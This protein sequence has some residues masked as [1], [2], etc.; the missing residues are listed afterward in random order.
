LKDEEPADN[1]LTSIELVL[2]NHN[3]LV[4]MSR[5]PGENE[6]TTIA[7]RTLGQVVHTIHHG[8]REERPLYSLLTSIE[9]VL[10][11]HNHLV[12]M[13]R[14]P[15]ENEVTTITV[16]TLGQVVHTIHHGLREEW[17]LYSL[18][19]SIELMLDY[20]NQWR[21]DEMPSVL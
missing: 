13:S 1:L 4:E 18:L 15:G 3:Q 7:V 10:D 6:V 16:R 20:D 12:E 21:R 14:L 17:P 11:N 19:T 2:D 9:L 8:L 5:L